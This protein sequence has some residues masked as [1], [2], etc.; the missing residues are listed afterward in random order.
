MAKKKQEES[1][2][3]QPSG[4]PSLETSPTLTSTSSTSSSTMSAFLNSS[5]E[6]AN[7]ANNDNNPVNLGVFKDVGVSEIHYV[8]IHDSTDT[9]KF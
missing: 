6:G 1:I 8:Q 3:F 5:Q 9:L 2:I 7:D 4:H